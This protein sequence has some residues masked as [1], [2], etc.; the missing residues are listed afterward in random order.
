MT[1]YLLSNVTTFWSPLAALLRVLVVA[2]VMLSSSG[3]VSLV[4]SSSHEHT[5]DCSD[6]DSGCPGSCDPHQCPPGPLCRCAPQLTSVSRVVVPS[7]TLVSS[8][9]HAFVVDTRIPASVVPDSI[10][11]P[12][13][14]LS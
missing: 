12:P 10:F 1:C 2:I 9:S 5:A 14:S 6:C 8:V 13:R 11:H 4:A 3:V 7:L